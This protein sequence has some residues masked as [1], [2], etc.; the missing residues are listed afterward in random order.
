MDSVLVGINTLINDNPSLNVRI[1]RKRT[2]QPV[3]LVLDS[4][5][6]TPAGSNILK[7]H[8]KAIIACSKD[9]KQTRK[10]I[11]ENAGAFV[12]PVATDKNGHIRIKQFL[13]KLVKMGITSVLLEGGSKVASSAIKEGL[14]D[15]LNIF[16][17]PKIV[18]GD[19]LSMIA[20]LNIDKMANAINVSHINIKKIGQEFMVEGYLNN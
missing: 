18:G 2:S 10:K 6:R 19:G 12:L 14:V 4:N 8:D 20:G 9:A 5:L 11:L 15:E 1:K 16:Y 7:I 13:K 3:P 17:S